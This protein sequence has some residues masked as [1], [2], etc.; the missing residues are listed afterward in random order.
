MED[1]IGQYLSNPVIIAAIVSALVAFFILYIREF[2]VEP[3]RWKVNLELHHLEEKLEAYGSLVTI[4][5]SAL[6]KGKRQT[7]EK[8]AIWCLESPYDSDRMQEIFEKHDYL[9]SPALRQRWLE[10]LREDKY[11]H[12]FS[13]KSKEAMLIEFD[14]AEMQRIAEMEYEALKKSYAKKAGIQID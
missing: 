4:L 8:E 2:W 11:F 9:L 12:L 5:K 13:A 6:E 7:K 3:R 14:L 10:M 1:L